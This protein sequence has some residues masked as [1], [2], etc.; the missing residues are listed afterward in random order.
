MKKL[1]FTV[2]AVL[3]FSNFSVVADEKVNVSFSSCED[4]A[5]DAVEY[6]YDN[7]GADGFD[8]GA[9]FEAVYTLC[10]VFNW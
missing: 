2:V 1:F 4:R 5:F 7:G 6:Y 8:A 3:A 10:T 9:Y